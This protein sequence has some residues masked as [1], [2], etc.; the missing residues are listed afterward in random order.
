MFMAAACRVDMSNPTFI[1]AWHV[2]L[3][4]SSEAASVDWLGP[5]AS[6]NFCC[7]GCYGM[8]WSCP[9]TAALR[10]HLEEPVFM[11]EQEYTSMR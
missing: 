7:F 11:F 9:H 2:R 6:S 1:M 5:R 3:A 10:A 8:H 4:G